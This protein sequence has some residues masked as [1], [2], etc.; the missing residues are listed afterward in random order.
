M[1]ALG[2]QASGVTTEVAQATLLG[3]QHYLL[4][5][6]S[7]GV[8][9]LQPRCSTSSAADPKSH[10][11]AQWGAETPG[12]ATAWDSRV[13]RAPADTPEDQRL[14][15][16]NTDSIRKTQVCPTFADTPIK[17]FLGFVHFP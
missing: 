10:L 13:R 7:S 11:W 15:H 17:H 3:P 2:S 8:Q 4:P 6:T 1:V 16:W 9:K 5:T 12:P 14:L